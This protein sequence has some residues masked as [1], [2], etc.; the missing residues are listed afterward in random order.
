MPDL[1]RETRELVDDFR[2]PLTLT[3]T[4]E[5]GAG[6]T[7]KITEATANT[8]FATAA[9]VDGLV[10]TFLSTSESKVATVY[11]NNIFQFD[12]DKIAEVEWVAKL[13]GMGAASACVIGLADTQNDTLDTVANSLWF[14]A[15]GTA[16]WNAESDDATTDNNDIATGVAQGTAFK[17]FVFD[18]SGT[19]GNAGKKDIKLSISNVD[20]RL[21]RVASGTVFN[22]NAYGGFLQPFVQMQKTAAADVPVL[23]IA[24]FRIRYKNEW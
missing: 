3:T 24:Q 21:T 20:G 2:R 23:S 18:F 12:I 14:R 22:M 11:H 1:I 6:W 10:V 13:T 16:S 5:G 4:P 8:T 9:S 7:K 17:R 15:D 19:P